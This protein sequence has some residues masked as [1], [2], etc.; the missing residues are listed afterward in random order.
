[1]LGSARSINAI[2]ENEWALL[3]K[4]DTLAINNWV[5]HPFFVPT[6]YFI[7]VKHYDYKIVQRRLAEKWREYC[8]CKFMFLKNKTV[9]FSDNSFHRVDA[10]VPPSAEIYDVEIKA[11]DTQRKGPIDANYKPSKSFVLTK[12]YDASVT[13]LLELGWR[14]GYNVIV[15]YGMDFY[16][17]YYF[18]SDG[19]QKYGTVHHL[20]NKAHEG[21]SPDAKYATYKIQNFIV[22]FSERWMR[23]QGKLMFVGSTDT[24]LYPKIPHVNLSRLE[25]VP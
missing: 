9:K 5:Y 24:T 18:W 12:S 25:G 1:M 2:S 7:E 15:L 6:F 13:M 3:K 14:M 20:T 21:K 10:L 22:D 4:C 17:S 11:R 8:K 16:H 23:A 19:S